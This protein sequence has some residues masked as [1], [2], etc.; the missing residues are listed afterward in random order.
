MKNILMLAVLLIS[1][2]ST[3][4]STLK[5]DGKYKIYTLPEDRIFQIVYQVINN[6]VDDEIINELVGP[7]RGF[8]TRMTFGPDWYNMVVKI[9]PVEGPDSSGK[10]V[11]GYFVELGGKGTYPTSRPRQIMNNILEELNKSGSGAYIKNFRKAEYTRERDRWRLNSSPSAR[12]KIQPSSNTNTYEDL[13]KLKKL[14][15]DE[16]ITTHEY[17]NKKKVLM[18]KIN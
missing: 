7:D 5:Q 12:N 1:A 10:T 13:R 18:D 9:V 8:A 6:V 4:I 2:C 15:D 11:K 14:L 17:E 3:H 16:I